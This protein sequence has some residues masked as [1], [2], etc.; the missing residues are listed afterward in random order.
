MRMI[1]CLTVDQIPSSSHVGVVLYRDAEVKGQPSGITYMAFAHLGDFRD[2][3]TKS[4]ADGSV[5]HGTYR[6]S[7][8][9]APLAVASPSETSAFV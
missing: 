5:K 8:N 1:E 6:A 9:G 3:E 7:H 4:I 2:W